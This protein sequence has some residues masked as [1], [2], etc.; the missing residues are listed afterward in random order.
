[1]AVVEYAN[2][3]LMQRRGDQFT[4]E[5]LHAAM[6]ESSEQPFTA[7]SPDL[8]IIN[9]GSE[10]E[11]KMILRPHH[12]GLESKVKLVHRPRPQQPEETPMNTD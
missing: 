11:V 6:L 7:I 12:E 9:E 5:V 3:S 10:C 1:M 4:L 2:Q 8:S